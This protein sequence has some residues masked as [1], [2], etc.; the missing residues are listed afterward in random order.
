M[1]IDG[2]GRQ[3]RQ[4]DG[5]DRDD[6]DH[7]DSTDT[8]YDT[9]DGLSAIGNVTF[10]ANDDDAVGITFSPASLA[11]REG[12]S[13]VTGEYTVV[14]DSEPTAEVTVAVAK[15]SGGSDDV[16]I[17]AS[18]TLTFSTTSWSSE[19]TVTVTVA[20]GLG[21]FG[22]LGGAGAHRLGRATTPR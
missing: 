20:D 10:T 9:D 21:R 18:T 7:A 11:I 6:L 14:L 8:D 12:D 13:D 19:Q 22:R 15:K 1:T 4:L 16:T 2:R 17:T 5:P 3:P